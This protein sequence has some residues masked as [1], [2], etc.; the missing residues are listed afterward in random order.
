LR[1]SVMFWTSSG[2]VVSTT[3]APRHQSCLG[4]GRSQARCRIPNRSGTEKRHCVRWPTVD[5]SPAD[6]EL[7]T[8][9][10]E[11]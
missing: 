2:T 4:L 9:R 11:S 8:S 10:K 1:S 7:D 6:A 5:G 3:H